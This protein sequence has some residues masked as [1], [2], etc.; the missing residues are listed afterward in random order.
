MNGVFDWLP[1]Y[2]RSSL[3][4]RCVALT[5]LILLMNVALPVSS[6]ETKQHRIEDVITH[7]QS[8]L[9]MDA[10]SGTILLEK[11]KIQLQ[12]YGI[13]GLTAIKSEHLHGRKGRSQLCK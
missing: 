4:K 2:T 1:R 11:N 12:V 6:A 3:G 9:L 7:A 8:A 5:A 10:D 13:S